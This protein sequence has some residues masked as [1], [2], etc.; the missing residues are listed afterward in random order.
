MFERRR[1]KVLRNATEGAERPGGQGGGELELELE[2]IQPHMALWV[3]SPG[4]MAGVR[5]GRSSAQ[6][7]RGPTVSESRESP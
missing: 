2:L 3:Q 1:A 6:V 5:K 4:A 7:R